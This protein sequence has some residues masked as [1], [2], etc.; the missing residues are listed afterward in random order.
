MSA[1]DESLDLARVAAQGAADRLASE[2]IG[3]DVSEQVVITDVFLV[4]SGDSER[5]VTAIVDGVEEALLKERSRKP[6]RREGERDARWV[7]LDYGDIVV[8]VQHAEDRA[9]Y[10]LERL[11]RDAPVLDLE[12]D[13]SVE[14]GGDAPSPE[15]S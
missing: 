1:P 9:F 7:L 4:C 15:A 14:R 13:H 8:H 3:L 10:A 11:W 12:S 2:V 6:L 5:Q